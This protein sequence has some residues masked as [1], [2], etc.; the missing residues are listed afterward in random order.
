MN[1]TTINP[2][3]WLQEERKLDGALLAGM[4]VTVIDH[5]SLGAAI[6]FPYRADGQSYAAKFRTVD[7]RW[8]SSKGKT[9]GLYNVDALRADYDLPI[10]ITEGEIDALSVIQSGFTRAV[11]LP[12]GWTEQGNKT[13]ALIEAEE[14]LRK[15]PFVIVAGDNDKAGESLPRAVCNLLDGMDVRFVEWPEGC[16]DANDVL[17]LMGEGAYRTA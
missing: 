1:T 8:S 12:D 7:K 2:I 11:S 14:D 4:G 10:V 6:A 15:A 17:M 3:T 16:K 13:D 5:P 9:R